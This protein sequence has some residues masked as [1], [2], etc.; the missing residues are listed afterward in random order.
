MEDKKK[1]ILRNKINTRNAA[2]WH[3]KRDGGILINIF[4]I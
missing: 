3:K 4:G 2:K 1:L